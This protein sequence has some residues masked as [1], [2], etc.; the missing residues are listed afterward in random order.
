MLRVTTEEKDGEVRLRLE[1]RLAGPWVEEVERS[2][3]AALAALGSRRLVVDLEEVDFVDAAGQELLAE[4]D[5][6]GARL[7][8]GCP[9]MRY[10]ISGI[11]RARRALKLASVLLLLAGIG[12]QGQTVPPEEAVRRYV[13][14][15]E[16]SQESGEVLVSASFEASLPKL[17]KSG[18]LRAFR[19]VTSRHVR[20]LPVSFEGD[21]AV[22][23]YVIA[24]YL[25]LEQDG[26]AG[27]S[28][29]VTPANYRFRFVEVADYNGAPA[30]VFRVEP[31]QKRAGLFRGELWLDAATFLPVREWGELVKSPSFFIRSVYFVQD[32]GIADGRAVPRRTIAEVKT[33]LA[34]PA[35]L[36]VWF[37][38]AQR[39]VTLEESQRMLLGKTD[40]HFSA[41]PV[42]SHA[43]TL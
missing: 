8:A 7:R 28:L 30:Y 16:R 42:G 43:C 40:V 41:D 36:T 31:K 24:R 2:W 1:G 34:G 21:R 39:C 13:S 4:M 15:T 26:T 19:I 23:R 6:Q 35:E 20:Y 3:R 38:G 14:A 9:L 5:R 37:G 10:L 33:R 27:A 25:S 11:G 22:E 29:A 32:Y 12:L 18:R 17:H